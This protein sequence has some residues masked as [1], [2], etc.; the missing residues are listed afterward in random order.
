MLR[1]TGSIPL[2][3]L[4]GIRIGVHPSW[5]LV[6]FGF[7]L[8]LSQPFK[9]ALS[10]SDSVAYVTAVVTVL[11]M[12]ASVVLHELGHALV[13]RRLG[14]EIAGIDLW[15]FG[16]IAKMSR[17]TDT[18]GAEFKVAVAGPLVT[19]AL[20]LI[21]CALGLAVAGSHNFLD[22]MGLRRGASVSPATLVLAWLALV[23]AFVF[24][25]NLIPAFPLD[26]GR[27]ARAIAWRKTGDRMRATRISAGV[28]QAFSYLLMGLGVFGV[29]QGDI[30][31]LWFLGLGFFLGQAARASV[32][33]T[34]FSERMRKVTV[35]D[36]MDSEPVSVP[37]G[38]SVERAREDFFLRYGWPW[39][40]VT[41]AAGRFVGLVRSERVEGAT[42]TGDGSGTVADVMEPDDGGWRVGADA[43]LE[44][45]LASAPLRAG[46]ALMAVDG[47]GILRG[48]VTLEQVRRALQSVATA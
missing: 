35:A 17:E 45:L 34:A 12:F 39:F 22:A 7:I 10:S 43:P 13:A 5:F 26:G 25:F 27:I 44:A 2:V 24:V 33:Q 37:A 46:G 31:G 15:M 40:P 3:R 42:G 18:P 4:F 11:A 23:N 38:L 9:E 47:E 36:I 32:F 30:Q 28:G 6:L 19:F 8:L 48:V 29:V 14:I 20:V 16:G 41:D 21:S 1:G